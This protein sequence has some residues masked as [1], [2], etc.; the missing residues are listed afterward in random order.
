MTLIQLLIWITVNS[1]KHSKA[2]A[3]INFV[4]AQL[5]YVKDSIAMCGKTFCIDIILFCHF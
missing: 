4:G 2:S 3:M 5:R 1:G